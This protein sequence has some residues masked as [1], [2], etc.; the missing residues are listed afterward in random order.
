MVARVLEVGEMKSHYLMGKEFPTLK[1][2][3]N[4]LKLGNWRSGTTLQM[5]QKPLNHVL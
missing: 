3:E 2:D 5:N 1:G 4:I